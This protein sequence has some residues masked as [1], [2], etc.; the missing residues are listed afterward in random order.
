V[1][2]PPFLVLEGGEAAGKSTQMEA[3]AG[4]LRDEGWEVIVTREPGGTAIGRRIRE[5]LLDP[6]STQ[7]TP[8]AEA[9][10]YAADRAQHVSQVIRPALKQG[11]AVLSDRFVDSSLAYQGVGRDLG[12]DMVL[13]ISSWATGGLLPDLVIYLDLHPEQAFARIERDL[14]R[15]ESQ[16]DDFHVRVHNGYLGLA[17]RFPERF[18]VVDASGDESQVRERVKAVLVE[19]GILHT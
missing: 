3:L 1:T 8:Q 5:V 18:E 14:D 17:S 4:F 2:K 6:S 10:L 7:L 19:R 15:I 12:V 11:R 13:E 9:L 16:G